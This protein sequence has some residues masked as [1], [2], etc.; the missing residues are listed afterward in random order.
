MQ[1]GVVDRGGVL[2]RGG[3]AS[4]AGQVL[5]VGVCWPILTINVARVVHNGGVQRIQG[6]REGGSGG[7]ARE[8]CAAGG[9]AVL[10]CV[11]VHR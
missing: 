3:H 5:R 10:L 7:A 4:L 1:H 8:I 9:A 6:R 2:G 11:Q